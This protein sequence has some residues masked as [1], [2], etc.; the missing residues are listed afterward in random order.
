MHR[1]AIRF[2][3]ENILKPLFFKRDPEFVHD[4]ISNIGHVL[5]KFTVTRYLT[6]S[7][8]QYRNEALIQ[9]VHGIRFEN[10]VGL[11]AGFDKDANLLQ[12]LPDIGFG[13]QQV[14]SVT[15]GAYEGNPGK[16]LHRLPKSRGLVVY[17]GLKNLGVH[18]IIERI[19][20][21]G[22]LR[23]PISISIAKT[24]DASTAQVEDGINDYIETFKILEKEEVGDFYTINISC[25]NTFGGEPFTTPE[26]LRL[27]MTEIDKLKSKK[28]V[29]IKMPI[30]PDWDKFDAL[31]KE[32]VKHSVQGVIISNLLKDHGDESIVDEV[33]DHIK[34][35]ISGKPTQKIANELISQTYKNYG[36]KLTIIGVGGVFSAEDA[37]E[38]IKLGST[39][40]QLI[41]GLVYEGPQ[42]IGEINKGLVELLKED[43][44]TNISESIGSGHAI[45]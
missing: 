23:F 27:L 18:K 2:S 25:P 24:N 16:R 19:K 12:I 33:P 36:D 11:S 37:Y 30:E 45:R 9:E 4:R 34:G 5:G 41:S 15:L 44:F 43:G 39:L 21:Y 1:T 40:V 8:L 14:G 29:F 26:R 3:Y 7:I 20:G 38:K 22:Q 6:R 32:I 31:L 28:P 13:F 10:P 17:Y 35:G 42:V